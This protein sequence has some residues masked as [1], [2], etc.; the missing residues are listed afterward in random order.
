VPVHAE[1]MEEEEEAGEAGWGA[2][3]GEIEV[4]RVKAGWDGRLVTVV[5]VTLVDGASGVLWERNAGLCRVAGQLP[6]TGVS[7]RVVPQLPLEHVGAHAAHGAGGR[8][9][10]GVGGDGL[11]LRVRVSLRRRHRPE[12]LH[13]CGVCPGHAQ[14]AHPGS[15]ELNRTWT[16]LAAGGAVGARMGTAVKTW[17]AGSVEQNV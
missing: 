16:G 9:A 5:E 11:R 10:A 4:G 6:G 15:P 2:E 1:V 13:R 7:R 3:G 12:D 14:H 17:Q 8:L